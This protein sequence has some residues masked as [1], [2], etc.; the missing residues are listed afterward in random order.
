MRFLILLS[1]MISCTQAYANEGKDGWPSGSAMAVGLEAR[2]KVNNNLEQIDII[3]H[4]L[5][6]QMTKNSPDD[7]RLIKAVKN[8]HA[9]WLKYHPTECELVGA[10]SGAG[11]SWPST[12][13][14][15][16]EQDLTSTKLINISSTIECINSIPE[17]RRK[18]G[19]SQ[20]LHQ[21]NVTAKDIISEQFK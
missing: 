1:I 15:V 8:Q 12:W 13:A 21:L 18:Y 7:S 14:T 19:Q 20:C 4:E 17:N 10:A 2:E 6:E 9:A 16:C 5:V 3:H 11:G